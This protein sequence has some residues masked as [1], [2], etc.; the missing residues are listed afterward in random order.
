MISLK[1]VSRGHPFFVLEGCLACDQIS[2]F[3]LIIDTITA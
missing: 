3:M 1:G 2:D